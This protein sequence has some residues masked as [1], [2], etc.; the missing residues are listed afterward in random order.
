MI[1]PAARR[2]GRRTSAAK[3]RASRENAR[4]GGRPPSDPVA[5]GA[6]AE[7]QTERRVEHDLARV[8]VMLAECDA[9]LRGIARTPE[10]EKRRKQIAAALQA[11]E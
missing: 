3:A 5:R 11:L 8:R 2:L 1:D 6:W 10:R 9:R 7:Q 4:L